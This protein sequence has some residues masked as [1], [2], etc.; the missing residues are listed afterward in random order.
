M[1]KP[2]APDQVMLV[3]LD[4]RQVEIVL[5]F[6]MGTRRC[7]IAGSDCTPEIF[8]CN[9]KSRGPLAPMENCIA[10]W[11]HGKHPIALE[12]VPHAAAVHEASELEAKY[13]KSKKRRG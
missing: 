4:N 5:M 13:G 2:L 12:A 6:T 7:I 8:D 9:V 11:R 10:L 1:P 3:W